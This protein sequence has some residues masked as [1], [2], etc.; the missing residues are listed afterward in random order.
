MRM[1]I[2]LWSDRVSV[3]ESALLSVS[4]MSNGVSGVDVVNAGT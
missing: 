3:L 1:L 4:S 2:S